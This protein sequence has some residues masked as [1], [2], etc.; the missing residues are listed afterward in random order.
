MDSSLCK[1]IFSPIPS[2]LFEILNL[3]LPLRGTVS[4]AIAQCISSLL[5]HDVVTI[6]LI[7]VPY[8]FPNGKEVREGFS[9]HIVYNFELIHTCFFYFPK[10]QPAMWQQEGSYAFF[11]RRLWTEILD[12]CCHWNIGKKFFNVV[13]NMY[14]IYKE[15]NH[16]CT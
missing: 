4:Y 10:L 14:L 15:K 9:V 5:Y 6:S 13:K 7:F 8:L 3:T 11:Y 12:E 16:T 1:L 2:I